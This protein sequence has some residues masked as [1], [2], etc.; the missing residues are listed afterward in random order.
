MMVLIASS[1]HLRRLLSFTLFALASVF[2]IAGPEQSLLE[3]RPAANHASSTV[4]LTCARHALSFQVDKDTY[5]HTGTE[6]PG[7]LSTSR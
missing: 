2:P 7:T 3:A 6:Q 4:P 5:T 1:T